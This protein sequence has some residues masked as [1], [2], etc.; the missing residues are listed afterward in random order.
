MTLD[1][2][3]QDSTTESIV[4]WMFSNHCTKKNPSLTTR[5]PHTHTSS[6]LGVEL[7]L[8]IW[9]RSKA[10]YTQYT[11]LPDWSAVAPRPMLLV[12]ASANLG[13]G[14]PPCPPQTGESSARQVT[15]AQWGGEGGKGTRNNLSAPHPITCTHVHEHAK[16]GNGQRNAKIISKKKLPKRGMCDA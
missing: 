8:Y 1:F 14:P 7:P 5:K 15:I 6:H 9:N 12:A 16:R 10:P 11:G 2:G 4:N 3:G 13:L